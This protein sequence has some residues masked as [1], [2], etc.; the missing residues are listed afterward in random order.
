[1]SFLKN[2]FGSSS[3]KEDVK[4]ALEKGAKIIDVRSPSEFSGGHVKG[5]EN[6]PLDKIAANVEKIKAYNTPI[7]LCCA[8]G[9]R[10]AQ[11]TSLLK[12][13]GIEAYNAG[14]W[15]NLN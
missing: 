3:G 4:Q 8:S 11:A 7:V 9:M 15:Q 12:E 13:K 2:L 5:S 1:M 10:S 6:I 14:G